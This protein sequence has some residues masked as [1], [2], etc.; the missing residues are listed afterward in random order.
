[1]ITRQEALNAKLSIMASK[2]PVASLRMH[3]Q[4]ELIL[5]SPSRNR[6]NNNAQIT[7]AISARVPTASMVIAPGKVP[8][9]ACQAALAMTN[10][11]NSPTDTPLS[12]AAPARHQH[13]KK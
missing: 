8:V 12:N 7:L 6:I 2:L 9:L 1:M 13:T 5:A 10:N 4:I 11:P 3:S